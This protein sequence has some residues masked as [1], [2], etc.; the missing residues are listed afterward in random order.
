MIKHVC[1]SI[2]GGL[3]LFASAALAQDEPNRT[4]VP[5]PPPPPPRTDVRV[6]GGVSAG[7]YLGIMLDDVT[8][9]NR[10]KLNLSEDYG[11]LVTKVTEGSPAADA[12]LRE[13]D[14][15]VGW[16]GTRIESASQLARMVRETPA[17]RKVSLD[18]VRDG[19]RT[20]I[21]AKVGKREMKEIGREFNIRMDSLNGRMHLLRQRMD[22]LGRV[23]GDS[24]GRFDFGDMKMYAPDGEHRMEFFIGNRGRLG[25]ELQPLTGQLAKYFGAEH[26]AL[27]SSVADSGAARTAGLR[28]GDIVVAIDGQIVKGPG[29]VTRI[30]REKKEGPVDVKIVREKREQTV[31]VQLPK[32]G[33]LEGMGSNFG[34]EIFGDGGNATI[35]QFFD[36]DTL[37]ELEDLKDLPELHELENMPVPPAP[38]GD[39]DFDNLPEG[40]T[41]ISNS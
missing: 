39:D 15:I 37:R 32:Q 10:S 6:W 20:T 41:E 17:G 34:Y 1:L 25:V 21:D 36:D 38:P 4:P 22:S 40:T 26:G 7:S 14:L 2:A 24:L 29:D 35:F 3:L 18:V 33:A 13:N 16:N 9:E 31:R 19:H 5:P 30:L 27:V 23:L 8:D 11:A 12:G 28:A